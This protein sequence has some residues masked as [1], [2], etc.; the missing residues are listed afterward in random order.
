[1]AKENDSFLPKFI[2]IFS[3]FFLNPPLVNNYVD[4]AAL[5]QKVILIP[6]VAKKYRPK[7]PP[8]NEGKLFPDLSREMEK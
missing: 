2:D 7:I 8:K 3:R 6:R 1:M 4:Y 5:S